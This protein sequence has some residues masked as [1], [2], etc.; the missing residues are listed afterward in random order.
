M[1]GGTHEE[2]WEA[3]QEGAELLREGEL[4]A[5]IVE[6]ERVIDGDPANE[7]AFFFLG[8][9]H[10]EKNAFEKA[11]KAYL[12]ALEIA[13]A[14]LGAM[15]S[16]GHTLRMLGRHQEAIRV[17]RQI[18]ARAP[19]DGDALH[20][21]GLSHYARGERAAAAQ[22]LERYLATRPELEAANEIQ[23]LLQVLRGE[24]DTS[25]NDPSLN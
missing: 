10:F 19:E 13:P 6:L 3:A 25:G 24:V 5:A 2:K 14:Y 21:L 18:L 22:Y 17:A 7:Y 11:L 23:G 20:L 12:K 4:D 16:L 9:A 15:V 1:S 8:S